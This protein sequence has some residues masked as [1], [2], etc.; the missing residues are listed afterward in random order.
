MRPRAASDRLKLEFHGSRAIGTPA[1]SIL[2]AESC[3]S[4]GRIATLDGA[5]RRD[6]AMRWVVG[7]K[8]VE[9]GGAST[10]QMGLPLADRH[11]SSG[12]WIDHA[13]NGHRAR[14]GSGRR[15]RPQE[16][17]S[18]DAAEPWREADRRRR[19]LPRV[20]RRSARSGPRPSLLKDRGGGG[21]PVGSSR[22]VAS[23]MSCRRRGPAT[24]DEH[25]KEGGLAVGARLGPVTGDRRR[26]QSGSL[27]TVGR[28]HRG[29]AEEGLQR[30]PSAAG[31]CAT[32]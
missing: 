6:P 13:R 4:A 5:R 29:M 3:P 18:A 9:R 16:P 7:G 1:I 12:S 15:R 30:L 17:P 27:R 11:R 28:R 24:S 32:V 10:S 23:I 20:G 14:H 2:A 21:S 8:A 22:R 25:I 31:G 26:S 19:L